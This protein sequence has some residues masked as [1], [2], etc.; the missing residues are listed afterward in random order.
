MDLNYQKWPRVEEEHITAIDKVVRSGDWHYGP[1]YKLLESDLKS[2]LGREIVSVFSCAWAIYLALKAMGPF[3]RVAVPVYTYHGTVHPVIWTNAEPVFIDVDPKTFNMCPDSLYK[4]LKNK[5][6]EAV[7]AV[8]IHGLPFDMEIVELCKKFNVFLIE[9]ACQALGGS[10]SGTPVGC[11]GQAAAFSFNARKT[12]PAGLGGAVAFKS[13]E[14]AEYAREI[15]NYGRKDTDGKILE[16]GSYLPIGEF[17]AALAR[18]QLTKLEASIKH[19]GNMAKL[20]NSILKKRAPFCN[21]NHIHTWHKYRIFGTK[22]ERSRLI[23]RGVITSSWVS[24]PL[25]D[26]PVYK[27]YLTDEKFPGATEIFNKSFC[28]FDDKHP[29]VAQKESLII[30]IK[31]IIMEE[32]CGN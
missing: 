15:R 28:L 18:V 17:D 8:H 3:K 9:D 14:H 31:N 22:D 20:L 30:K 23:E 10:T 11:F 21:N 13:E 5:N 1:I 26:F 12:T 32:L 24:K 27:K 16:C 2:I 29:I 4:A 6:I 25:Y 7:I 19:A